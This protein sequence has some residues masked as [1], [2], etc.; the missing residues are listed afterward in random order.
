M[1]RWLDYRIYEWYN[2]NPLVEDGEKQKMLE[3]MD[4]NQKNVNS[5]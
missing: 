4:E 2:G 3:F 5:I 1:G